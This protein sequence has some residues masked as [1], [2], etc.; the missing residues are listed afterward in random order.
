MD[1]G[2]PHWSSN[3]RADSQTGFLLLRR[4]PNADKASIL[5]DSWP[6]SDNSMT[7]ARVP[8]SRISLIA[9]MSG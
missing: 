5:Q 1:G 8:G 2:R 4:L 7:N 3:A 6:F 9:E